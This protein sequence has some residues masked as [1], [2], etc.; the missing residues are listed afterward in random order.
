MNGTHRDW[1]LTGN[2]LVLDGTL[3]S[4]STKVK[5]FRCTTLDDVTHVS[6]RM[7]NSCRGTAILKLLKSG[8]E[9][10]PY[11]GEDDSAVIL[12]LHEQDALPQYR[13]YDRL[14]SPKR[15]A[16]AAFE[17]ITPIVMSSEDADIGETRKWLLTYCGSP[18]AITTGGDVQIEN[19]DVLVLW[20][21]F[22]TPHSYVYLEFSSVVS[23]TKLLRA[24]SM[25]RDFKLNPILGFKCLCILKKGAHTDHPA[26]IT[27]F[28]QRKARS[29]NEDAAP[30]FIEWINP[31]RLDDLGIMNRVTE[32]ALAS[33]RLGQLQI[34]NSTIYA[35]IQSIRAISQEMRL[36]Q[37]ASPLSPNHNSLL[38]RA[39]AALSMYD[40]GI[41]VASGDPVDDDTITDLPELS[42]N[43]SQPKCTCWLLE[44][45][46]AHAHLDDSNLN[47]A[48][49]VWSTSVF[50]NMYA[51]VHFQSR[52]SSKNIL[53][54]LKFVPRTLVIATPDH[55]IVTLL[56][57]HC[58]KANDFFCAW[59]KDG[60]SGYMLPKIVCRGSPSSQSKEA[61]A[62]STARPECVRISNA[63]DGYRKQIAEIEMTVTGRVVMTSPVEEQKER[64]EMRKLMMSL[65]AA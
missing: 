16:D 31:L 17:E 12:K 30:E 55:A 20:R 23:T 51:C 46:V 18:T 10:R 19:I 42:V 14:D 47:G 50:Q 7:C 29:E 57:K 26:M 1:L 3:L 59:H 9:I 13:S 48:T 58:M 54:R 34:P 49:H 45:D 4:S 60:R 6:I 43:N 41:F 65:Q 36:A 52:C 56:L 2:K 53:K 37:V 32:A 61:C 25:L 22:V 44:Y 39:K 8:W 5:S 35:H 40:S 24:L 33:V 63:L 28:Q 15:K 11:N 62:Y 27:L 64:I 38:G 21:T